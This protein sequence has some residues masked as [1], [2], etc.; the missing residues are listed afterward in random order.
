ME[1]KKVLGKIL[2]A[3]LVLVL[4]LLLVITI[5][6]CSR[7]KKTPVGE[8]VDEKNYLKIDLAN[9]ETYAVSK[10]DFYNKLRYVGYD[11]FEDALYEAVLKDY[12]D[13]IKKDI[14]DNSADLENG[15][16]FKKF[17]YIIDNA[18]Y[19]TTKQNE[20]DNLDEADKL[21]KENAYLNQIKK[22]GYD[23]DYAKGVYQKSSLEYQTLTLAKRE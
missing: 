3:V 5:S 15:A 19:G 11:V 17:K 8:I 14:E 13:P 1:N 18:V 2:P 6:S 23:V 22:A 10:L 9:N 20:I 16:Y 21:Q 4:A 12:V 7:N